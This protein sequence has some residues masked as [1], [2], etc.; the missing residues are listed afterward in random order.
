MAEGMRLMNSASFGYE[1]DF[2][3]SLPTSIPK[4]ANPAQEKTMKTTTQATGKNKSKASGRQSGGS[5]GP[6]RCMSTD[7]CPR[8]Q[9]I[10]EAAYFRAEQRGFAP[11]NEMSDWFQAEADVEGL[12][13]SN[14]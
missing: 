13:R 7:A 11:G 4:T 5:G 6:D 8:E 2:S 3:F 9:M 12:L 10:A 14:T 1:G